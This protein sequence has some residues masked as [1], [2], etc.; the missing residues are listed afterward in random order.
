MTRLDFILK[1]FKKTGKQDPQQAIND[2]VRILRAEFKSNVSSLYLYNSHHKSFVLVANKGLYLKP[3]TKI[4]LSKEEGLIGL[5]ARRE[6]LLNLSDATKHVHFKPIANTG[7]NKYPSFTAVP[8]VYQQQCLGV[9]VQQQLK[10]KKLNARE[11]GS[12]LTVATTLSYVISQWDSDGT[13][14]QLTQIDDSLKSEDQSYRGLPAS[15]GIA[16][17]TAHIIEEYRTD[18]IENTKLE[19]CDNIEEEITIFSHAIAIVRID[20][21]KESNDLVGLIS[22]SDHMIFTTYVQLLDDNN[23]GGEVKKLI[24]QKYSAI[25]AWNY[26]INKH[27]QNIS[28]I[29]DQ[30]LRSRITDIR[31]L[32]K[33]VLQK[34]NK[35]LDQ[36]KFPKQPTIL[37]ASEI[38]PSIMLNA[39]REY[40]A[41]MIS[42]KGSINSHVSIIARSLGIPTVIGLSGFNM[43]KYRNKELIVDGSN[44]IVISQL[45]ADTIAKY[46]VIIAENNEF[47]SSLN[48]FEQDAITTTSDGVNIEL[49]VN[50]GLFEKDK[51]QI[52]NHYSVGLY[53]SESIFFNRNVFPTEEEQMSF[54]QKELELTHPNQVTIRTLDIGGDKQLPYFTITEDNPYLGWRGIRVSLDHPEL[55]IIQLRAMLKA[56]IG[57]ENLRILLPMVSFYSE[58]KQ[59]YHIIDETH[60][61]LISEGYL[62]VIMPPIG[63]MIEVPSMIFQISQLAGKADFLSVGT[64]DLIQYIQAVDRNNLDVSSCYRP[65]DPSILAVLNHIKKEAETAQLEISICGEL[66]SNFYGFVPLLAMGYRQLSM[67]FQ[68]IKSAK[69]VIRAVSISDCQKLLTKLLTMHSEKEV[70]AAIDHYLLKEVN[71]DS[72]LKFL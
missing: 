29:G 60:K 57:L 6:E 9:I 36:K 5:V 71:I 49:Q 25:S 3:D 51:T 23:L 53:R 41:G 37:I 69:A 17:G 62:D 14:L 59:V 61:S 2:L 34:L 52:I 43:K 65:L 50:S 38:T 31:D 12:L 72:H 7:E 55:F 39:P 8:I 46:K 33:R 44:G 47:S 67:N 26:I 42:I 21:L 24:K 4:I 13:L 63:V 11:V 19:D 68:Q 35:D 56:N 18:D 66:A 70:I 22:D 58:F 32:G 54:Y 45:T 15:Q 48:S 20:I 10:N 27:C 16:L 40:L 28:L 1:N 64:N 30:Y